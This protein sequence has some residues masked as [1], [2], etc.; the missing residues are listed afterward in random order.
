MVGSSEIAS[1]AILLLRPHRAQAVPGLLVLRGRRGRLHG[2]SNAAAPRPGMV[3]GRIIM[4]GE[5]AAITGTTSPPTTTTTLPDC[6]VGQRGHDRLGTAFDDHGGTGRCDHH[7]RSRCR[8]S[9]RRA[10]PVRKPPSR[11]MAN[12]GVASGSVK[13]GSGSPRAYRRPGSAHRWPQQRRVRERAPLVLQVTAGEVAGAGSPPAIARGAAEIAAE[14]R[15]GYDP[16]NDPP[17]SAIHPVAAAPRR[18][19]AGNAS[20]DPRRGAAQAPSG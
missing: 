13:M 12:G 20:A 7:R 11:R 14:A 16:P 3:R 1:V 15:P 19:C 17:I 9:G 8:H 6:A 10:P 4:S 5:V 2:L 18:P